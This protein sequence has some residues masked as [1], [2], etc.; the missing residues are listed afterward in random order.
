MKIIFAVLVFSATFFACGGGYT[1]ST[2]IRVEKGFLKFTGNTES[3]IISVD[4]Q[5]QFAY[6]PKIDLYEVKP[7]R[8]IVKIQRNKLI[9]VNRIIIV[10]NQTTVEIDVP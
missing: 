1:S 10:D 5:P 4:D 7:G 2:V 3:V 9:I 8:H 6:D